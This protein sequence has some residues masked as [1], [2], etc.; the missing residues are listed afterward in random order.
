MVNNTA[1]ICY[2]HSEYSDIWGMFFGQLNKYFPDVKKYLFT[3]KVNKPISDDINV[4]IYDDSLSYSHRVAYCLEKVN[5]KICLFHHEDM[6]LYNNPNIKNLNKLCH[7]LSEYN[8][9]YIKLLKGGKFQDTRLPNI[10]LKQL[11]YLN[12]DEY[13]LTFAIQPTL[14]KVNNL[15]EVYKNSIPTDT[16]G[17][18]AAGGFE[19]QGSQYINN[20]N[21]I[22][23]YWYDNEIK[24]GLHHYNSSVYPHGNFVSKGKWIYSE[25]SNELIEL[26]KKY[27]INKNI[28]GIV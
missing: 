11:Y 6:I 26:H 12:K 3:D 13:M 19:L 15:Y 16:K 2:S 28:R 18:A 14:W 8:V 4:I 5:E 21:M 20:T 25:Y 17:I 7:F 24:R 22:G 27:N 23:L 9:S 1:F 10:P